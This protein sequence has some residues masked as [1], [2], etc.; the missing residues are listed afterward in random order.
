MSRGANVIKRLFARASA[1]PWTAVRSH[2][3]VFGRPTGAVY[4]AALARYTDEQL[5]AHGDRIVAELRRQRQR[6]TCRPAA[7]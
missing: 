4:R 3:A 6:L 1:Q 7:A 2:T 5:Y